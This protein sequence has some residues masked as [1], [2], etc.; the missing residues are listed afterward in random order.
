MTETHSAHLSDQVTD[1]LVSDVRHETFRIT[2]DL[3]ADRAAA[4]AAFADDR[5]R[6]R[7]FRI[8][9]KGATYDHDFR[10]SGGEDARSTFVMPDGATERL[11]NR[12]RYLD[13]V[14]NRFI[15]FVYE[16][17]VDDVTRWVSLVTVA[18]EDAESGGSTLTWTEQVTFLTRTGDGSADLPHLR[19]GTTLR[20]NGLPTA[21]EA[22]RSGR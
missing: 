19:T 14:P 5:V 9:G 2:R 15:V 3:E 21:I 17:I 7:W 12:S 11:R 4:F 20:L 13:I 22:E 16:A 8:P 18:F 10:I 1:E 6:R